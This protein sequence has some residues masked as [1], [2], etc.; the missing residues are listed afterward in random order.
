MRERITVSKGL[1]PDLTKPRYWDYNKAMN[2][3]F[4]EVQYWKNCLFGGMVDVVT[5]NY[6]RLQNQGV[7]VNNPM[8]K[9]MFNLQQ[10]PYRLYA[11]GQC[12]YLV[13]SE[14]QSV[15]PARFP[16]GNSLS[17]I[18][19]NVFLSYQ[20]ESLIAQT[21][22]WANIDVS[23]IQGLASLGELPETV[24]M[25]VDLLKQIVSL[26]L[27]AKRGDIKTIASKARAVGFTVDGLADLWLGYRYGIRP[28]VG[29]VMNLLKAMNADLEKGMRFT[30]RGRNIIE[31]KSTQLT[32]EITT[33]MWDSVNN[34]GAKLRVVEET[35]TAASFRAGVMVQVDRNINQMAAVWGLDSPFEAAWELV[36]FSFILDWVVNIG[37]CLG[38]AFLN[39]S[40]TPRNSWVTEQLTFVQ[41]V[42]SLDVIDYNVEGR[43]S[44]SLVKTFVSEHGSTKQTIVAKRRVPLAHRFNLPRL[45]LNLDWAKFADLLLI[46]RKIF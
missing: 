29:D 44:R 25:I 32:K 11:K 41:D 39:P 7:I 34:R 33:P 45:N 26:T 3:H 10:V 46:A 40:L 15:I 38:A 17:A 16:L 21:S 43:C 1:I 42:R 18:V 28:L 35:T 13:I 36:P 9:L 5:P 31:P 19:D 22:A 14:P 20:S 27:A 4:P 12:Q 30:A 23:E 24:K 37:D 8:W 2:N 6:K